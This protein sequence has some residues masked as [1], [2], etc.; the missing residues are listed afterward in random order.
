[1]MRL[2][3]SGRRVLGLFPHPDDEAYTAGGT[4]ALCARRGATVTIGCATRGE[5]GTDRANRTAAGDALGAVRVAELDASCR[6]IG[7]AP[8]LLFD[9]P[10]GALASTD[11]AAAVTLVVDVVARTTPEVVITLGRDGVYGSADHVAWTDIV[12]TALHG[13]SEAAPR[14]LHTAF[15]RGLFDP[16]RRALGRTGQHSLVRPETGA[17]GTD[18]ADVDLRICIDE[19]R[20]RKIAAV[21]AHRS[22]L[23]DGDPRSFL[24]TGLLDALLSEEWFTLAAGPPLPGGATDPFAGL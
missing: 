16:L 2:P 17:L 12:M 5:H 13:G 4:L 3:W 18:L 20:G 14:I 15:P 6:A 21:A 10:D 8:P 11:R 19:V 9:L 1:M 23:A 7:A 22:Q 24:R